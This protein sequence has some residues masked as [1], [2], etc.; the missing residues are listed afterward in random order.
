MRTMHSTRSVYG[1]P[2]AG[3]QST[4]FYLM[5]GAATLVLVWLTV[6][7]GPSTWGLLLQV[8]IHASRL[9]A[10]QGI[11]VLGIIILLLVQSLLLLAAWLLLILTVVREISRLHLDSFEAEKKPSTLP[12]PP[13]SGTAGSMVAVSFQGV[14]PAPLSAQ[15]LP[16]EQ[17]TARD[18]T[19]PLRKIRLDAPASD[20]PMEQTIY[21]TEVTKQNDL[22]QSLDGLRIL[23]WQEAFPVAANYTQLPFP[24]QEQPLDEK[25]K[26]SRQDARSVSDGIAKVSNIPEAH[27][28][29]EV[30]NIYGQVGQSLAQGFHP[31]PKKEGDGGVPDDPFAVQ[32]N[33]FEMLQQ[34]QPVEEAKA[35]SR[36]EHQSGEQ[37]FVFGN[38][39]EGILP[40]VFEHDVDLK[41]SLAEQDNHPHSRNA[42]DR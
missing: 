11:G 37:E 21:V 25:L 20:T 41:R 12:V 28:P 18:R 35:Q 32:E 33:V 8:I 19:G 4:R 42:A 1:E 38:P 26:E 10:Q 39:F 40:D 15:S 2:S 17:H 29:Y 30:T 9:W 14:S 36:P 16:V 7:T 5:A 34:A 13:A 22:M 23:D 6:G 3:R 27:D 31:V 24:Q